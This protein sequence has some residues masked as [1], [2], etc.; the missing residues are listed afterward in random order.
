MPDG[1]A[2]VGAGEDKG[3]S[4]YVLA[5]VAVELHDSV[6]CQLPNW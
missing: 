5:L 4:L 1:L 6:L 2:A 3:T